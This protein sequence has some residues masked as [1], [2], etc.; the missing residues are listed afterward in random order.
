MSIIT[1]PLYRPLFE[2]LKSARNGIV[3]GGKLR[4]SHALVINL[5]YR[6]GPIVPRLKSVLE[7][8]KDHAQVLAAFAIIYKA[9]VMILKQDAFLG[10]KNLGLIKFIAGSFGSWIVY[11]QHFNFFHGGI[12]HQ[13]TLYCFSRVVLALSKIL[14]DKYLN[15]FQPGFRNY[16][17]ELIH[18]KDLNNQQQ[19]KLKN[20]VYNK[21]WK[22][23]AVL[24]WG[25]VMLI[26]DYQ[27]QYLQSSLRH[28]MA[29]IYDV[30]MDTW[31]NWREF[32]GV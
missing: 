10:D 2:V 16:Q 18:Y 27:P 32:L 6:S 19:K 31:S 30:E 23:F 28:S 15:C 9:C 8:T 14:L 1:N 24:T 22:Y 12:T 26:Y 20:I 3:Y 4:F 11:S 13:I 7:A 25:L 5:L 21:S 17:G 29:Y